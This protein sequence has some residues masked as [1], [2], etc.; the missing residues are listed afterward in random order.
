M[1]HLSLVVALVLSLTWLAPGG[2]VAQ[3]KPIELKLASWLGIGHNHHKNVLVPWAK[4]VEERSKGRLKVTIYPGG[5]LGK[6]GDQW[7]MIRDGVA[8]IGYA[9]H[10]Y[11]PGRFPLTAAGNL[12]F[13]FKTAKGGSRAMWELYQKDL[14]KEHEGVKVL[15]LF[16]HSPA[17][18]H[19]T[20]KPVKTIEDLAGTKIRVSGGQVAQIVKTLG[21]VPVTMAAPESYTAL[22]RGVVD[23][24]V[25]PWEAI[26]GFKLYEVIKHHTVSNLYVGT[27]W[28]GMNQKKY[29]S[30]P[31]DLKKVIDDRSGSWGAEFT[32]GAW[33]KGEED[34]IAAAKKAGATTYTLPSAELQRWVQKAKPIEEEWIGGL[35]AKGLPVRQVVSDLR[36]LA[37]K[38]DP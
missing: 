19:T 30:L 33:D 10:N 25:F 31:P 16:V 5:T 4:L 11:T 2:A 23:G 13:M 1:R 37:K 26:F 28:F 7:D 24:T 12:P 15:W 20:K 14:K 9:D 27:F 21:A 17:Q 8:D 18:F 36:E 22:E 3:D 32:G 35:E 34:G 6:P 29:D 38:Y